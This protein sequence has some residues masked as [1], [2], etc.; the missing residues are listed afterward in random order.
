MM[1]SK[2]HHTNHC[3]AV[4]FGLC[5][6]LSDVPQPYHVPVWAAAVSL[7]RRMANSLVW[8]HQQGRQKSRLRGSSFCRPCRGFSRSLASPT[9]HAVGY[10]LT[11]LRGYI[12]NAL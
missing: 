7:G 4:D 11:P 8:Q 1:P 3:P 10:F 6:G 9:A 5:S 12:E 2:T